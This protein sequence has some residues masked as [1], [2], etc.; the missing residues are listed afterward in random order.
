LFSYNGSQQTKEKAGFT[1]IELII[2]VAIIAI[3]GLAVIP[4]FFTVGPFQQRVFYDS[5]L[6]A[7]QYAQKVAVA[8]GCHIEVSLPNATTIT[9][10]QRD[11]CRS[12]NFNNTVPVFDPLSNAAGYTRASPS[13]SVTVSSSDLPIYFDGIGEC[14]K[15]STGLP[16]NYAVT[17]GGQLINISC[18]TG[19]SYGT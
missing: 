2:V 10:K 13:S 18:T 9:L 5:V 8:T 14:I 17:V 11:G 15:E 16:G 3:L 6:N 7:L 19:Y 4:K 1:F 12:G